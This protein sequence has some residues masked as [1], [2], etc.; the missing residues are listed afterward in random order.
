MY[1]LGISC[2]Y[3]DSAA[4]IIKDGVLIAASEEERFS[5]K[6]HDFG[7]PQK[8]IDFCLE[9]AGITAQ[10]LDHVVF[11]EK[12]LE[13]FERILMTTLQTFPKSWGVFRESMIAWFNEKLW[14]KGEI[15][16]KLDI[17]DNKLL[18]VEHHLSHAASAFFC[19]PYEEAAI[20]TVDGVGEWTT[21]TVGKGTAVWTTLPDG[22]PSTQTSNGIDLFRELK[23]P[24]SLGL[25]YSAFTAFLGFRVNNGEYKVMGMSPYGRPTRMDDVYKVINVADDASFRLNMDYF[26]FHH[27]TNRTFGKKFIDLF[28]EPRV[29]DSVFYTPTTHPNQDHPQWDSATAQRNQYYADIA[30]SIQKVTEE[31]MLKM[32]QYAYEQTGSENLCMAG[33]VALNSVANGRIMREGPFKNVYIQPAAGDAG[34]A[35]GAALYAYH[36]LLGKPRTF[37]MDSA[38]WGKSYTHDEIKTAIGEYG[39]KYEYSDDVDKLASCMVDDMLGKKVIALYQGR[40]EWGPR[41]LGNRSIMAD[42]RGPEMKSI[43]NERI[44]FREPF[45]P[46]APVVLEERADEFW[47]DLGEHS[48]KYPYRYMLAV[49]RTKPGVGH[50]IQAVNHEGSGRIQ[51]VRREWNPLYYRSI[52]LFGEATGVPV[53][54]NTSFNLR[55]EP[56]VTT[57]SN[58]LNTFTKSDID[59]LYMDGFIVRKNGSNG[60]G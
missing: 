25:L 5:R 39:Y 11:Y 8:A 27:S 4:A 60:Q 56:I 12:P 18:F 55:G 50:K 29:H 19:S 24:H 45:R 49:A 28:G 52:E 13:K 41:A 32:V 47:E 7:F 22:S 33:G 15:L 48:V 31:T 17:P 38:Y 54:L 9:Q 59:T 40:F 58:A 30:S 6:K 2:Y 16:T 42:P 57:P 3:H 23:F 10:D 14:I 44:K 36:V 26:T 20:L 46:F 51:T 34:G 1:I 35:L 37:M 43:V 53:L 21:T